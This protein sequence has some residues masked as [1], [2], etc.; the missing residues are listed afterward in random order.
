MRIGVGGNDGQH[1]EEDGK[2]D[3]GRNESANMRIVRCHAQSPV[4]A[5][6]YAV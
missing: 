2:Y 5:V 6:I 4:F 3:S 1:I